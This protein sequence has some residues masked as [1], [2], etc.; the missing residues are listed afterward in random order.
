MNMRK[1]ETEQNKKKKKNIHFSHLLLFTTIQRHNLTATC[2]PSLLSDD[3]TAYT[4]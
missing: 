1:N 4:C 3:P 2:S